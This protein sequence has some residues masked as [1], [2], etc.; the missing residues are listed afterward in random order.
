MKKLMTV[1]AVA[2]SLAFGGCDPEENPKHYGTYNG[3]VYAA[4]GDVVP[5]EW[6]CQYTKARAYA[7]RH[8]L[9]FVFFW[10]NDGCGVCASAERSIA[11]TDFVAWMRKSGYVFAFDVK[12]AVGGAEAD[13][14]KSTLGS[15]PK[16]PGVGFYWPKNGSDT[17]AYDAKT[18]GP[19]TAADI[20]AEA[21]R[22]FK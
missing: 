1:A 16:Y 21:A 2:I 19:M 6:T 18:Y 7:V 13:L 3:V 22:V 15:V 10:G 8:R 5:G 12:G 11:G 17:V 4:D 20:M 9:P 14:M